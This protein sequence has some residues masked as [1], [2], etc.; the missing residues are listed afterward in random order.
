MTRLWLISLVLFVSVFPEISHASA[1]QRGCEEP[2]I[3]CPD[4]S[5]PSP[6]GGDCDDSEH[7]AH[8]MSG[9]FHGGLTV[10]DTME[11]IVP[12]EPILVHPLTLQVPSSRSLEPD[13][14]PPITLS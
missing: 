4:R 2:S 1:L 3:T 5:I 6:V 12:T 8:C 9:C 13:L 14:R 7:D 11:I 10:D